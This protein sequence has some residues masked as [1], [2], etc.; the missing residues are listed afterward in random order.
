MAGMATTYEIAHDFN[1]API[2]SDE[3]PAFTHIAANV[4]IPVANIAIIN[5]KA[6]FFFT[7]QF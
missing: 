1:Q 4:T 7:I 6:N 5:A 2:N 3:K